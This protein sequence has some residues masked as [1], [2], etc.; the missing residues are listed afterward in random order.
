MKPHFAKTLILAGDGKGSGGVWTGGDQVSGHQG[1]LLSGIHLKVELHDPRAVSLLG[2]TIP[3]GML[4][5]IVGT[6]ATIRPARLTQTPGGKING[7][8]T[9][10]VDFKAAA[11]IAHAGITEMIIYLS[12]ETHW[13]VRQIIVPT[14]RTIVARQSVIDLKTN[15]GLTQNDFPF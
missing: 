11:P 15:T 4:Q 8:P 12:Q 14:A 7:V 2:F 6:V 1:G 10:R 3:D 13:P 9:D 5:T